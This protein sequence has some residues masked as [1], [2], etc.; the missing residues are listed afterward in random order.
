MS[1]R[2]GMGIPNNHSNPARAISA[3]CVSDRLPTGEP[4]PSSRFG[5]GKASALHPHLGGSVRN[6]THTRNGFGLPSDYGQSLTAVLKL[7]VQVGHARQSAWRLRVTTDSGAIPGTLRRGGVSLMDGSNRS[8][9][10]I[11]L[12]T[13]VGRFR[14]RLTGVGPGLAVLAAGII[15]QHY[16]S[17]LH[18]H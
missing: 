18:S 12:K 14:P 13:S 10:E 17:M 15:G 9:P 4:R 3:S 5:M 7:R 16:C 6:R 2:M 1:K 8:R 11:S